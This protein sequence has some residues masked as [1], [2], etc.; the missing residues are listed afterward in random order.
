VPSLTHA[1]V[2]ALTKQTQ[3]LVRESLTDPGRRELHGDHTLNEV[4]D[5]FLSEFGYIEGEKR[6]GRLSRKEP[7]IAKLC[8]KG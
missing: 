4:R 3:D 8:G 5:L 7:T 6:N 2:S 1:C